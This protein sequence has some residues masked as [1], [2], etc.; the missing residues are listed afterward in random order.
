M[1]VIIGGSAAALGC[2]EGIRSL[3]KTTPIT[4][5]SDE[6]EYGYS[7]PLISYLLEGKTTQEKMSL[8][9]KEFYQQ[10]KVTV[11]AGKRAVQVDPDAH[12]VK[13]DDGSTVLYTKLLLAAGSRPFVP[14][15]QGLETVYQKYTFMTL[16]DAQKLHAAL[17]PNSRVL[18]LGAGLT[19][20]KC[21]EG[22]AKRCGQISI[23]DLAPRVL[24]AVLD[25][26]AAS[27]VQCRM[28]QEGIRFYLGNS[29]E[30][31]EHNTAVL[32]SGEKLDFD[33]LVVAVGVRANVE[34]LQEAGAKVER[35]V[36]INLRCQ[37]SLPDIF[38]AGDCAQGHDAAMDENQILPLW[39]S[40][41]MQGETAGINMAGGN[42][43]PDRDM[44]INATGVFGLHMIT[45]GSYEGEDY[46]EKTHTSYKRLIIDS[47]LLRGVIMVG[48]VARAG[49]YT[50]L[51]RTRTPLGV[52]DYE[53]IKKSP[54]LMAF[55][56]PERQRQLGGVV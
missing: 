28:E 52:I 24:P 33:I 35:G 51:I 9:T 14:P 31:F 54:Q 32:K 50:N 25:D 55:S 20:V 26:V 36:V 16:E 23:V 41:V 30:R 5:I 39:P 37:T 18:I 12:E 15:V 1:Y 49:I 47:G 17:T 8:R 27:M 48:D 11:L 13:L 3:D 45:A 21:A 46:I 7:R 42:A 6:K 29:V 22:I 34:L 44:A 43:A 53:L 40:A 19:G 38:A 10:N 2:I 4:I 56:K